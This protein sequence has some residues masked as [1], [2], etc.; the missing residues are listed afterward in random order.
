MDGGGIEI[1]ARSMLPPVV[2]VLACL[3]LRVLA[4]GAE[5]WWDLCEWVDSFEVVR[6]RASMAEGQGMSEGREG[7]HARVGW[8]Y[9]YSCNN[10][11]AP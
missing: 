2:S 6:E 4:D 3:P 7:N 10:L 9:S 11:Q 8:L 1:F 5:R